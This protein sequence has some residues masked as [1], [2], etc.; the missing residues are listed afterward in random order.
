MG[1]L[2][3]SMRQHANSLLEE[4]IELLDVPKSYYE[5]AAKRYQ[6]VA[7][8][9]SR[10]ESA[11]YHMSPDVYLQGSF[12]YGTVI[13]PLFKSD[14]YDLDMV[15]QIKASKSKYTQ[16]QIKRLIGGEIKSYAKQNNFKEP[17]KEKKRC[18]RL[19]YADDVSFHMDI[20]PAIQED[21]QTIALLYQAIKASGQDV[22]PAL[23]KFAIAITDNEHPDYR[24]IT[25]LWPSSNARGI[26]SWFEGRMK[27]AA[28][29]IIE[30]LVRNKVYAS[31]EDVP[32]YEWKTPLQR[33]IQLFKRHRDVMFKGKPK[34]KP[35]SMILTTLSAH[36]YEGESNIADCV[37]TILHNMKNYVNRVAPW[38]INPVNPAEDFAEKWED[39]RLRESFEAWYANACRD[40][41]EIFKSS[42]GNLKTVLKRGFDIEYSSLKRS[43]GVATAAVP[44][45][46]IPKPKPVH[47]TTPTR[48][49]GTA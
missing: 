4:M 10:K 6:A 36:A 30:D 44:S 7:E 43:L 3:P 46:H 40:F 45:I 27:T 34:L 14:L 2:T 49:W 35:I 32:P 38:V 9:L 13:R 41:Q 22:D 17:A 29:P 37:D 20:L 33:A 24:T 25:Q 48:P 39:P 47:I 1:R 8:H 11:V 18:W 19:D 15:C 16:M 12:R 26:A 21:P 23:A 31:I 28:M 42:N 5:L